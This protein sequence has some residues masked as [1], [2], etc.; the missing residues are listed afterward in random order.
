[1][2]KCIF[3][4]LII[5]FVV[6]IVA[7]AARA[8]TTIAIDGRLITDAVGGTEFS[9]DASMATGSA[10]PDVV[11][12]DATLSMTLS[13]PQF[14]HSN[15]TPANEYDAG[16]EWNIRQAAVAGTVS[17]SAADAFTN[18]SYLEITLDS[19]AQASELFDLNSIS[20]SL[21]RNGA[22]APDNFQLAVDADNNG[23]DAADLLG[24]SSV[25]ASGIDGA[26]TISAS[27]LT[28]GVTVETLRLY[29]W[30]NTATSNKAGNFHIYDVAADYTVVPEPSTIAML[31]LGGLAL[32][33][34]KK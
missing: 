33:R 29:Y 4:M 24:V 27:G 10:V 17:K 34:R 9:G 26:T 16:E 14:W 20:V 22:Q 15:W 6:V 8:A 5:I 12:T 1:M 28:T 3:R 7:N 19:S 32:R 11:V 25:L 18:N 31:A 13:T 21:W 30:D 23:F 2:Q